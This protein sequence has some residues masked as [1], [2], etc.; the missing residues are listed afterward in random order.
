MGR[1]SRIAVVS[2]VVLVTLALLAMPGLASADSGLKIAG[3]ASVPGGTL[4][5]PL[6]KGDTPVTIEVELGVPAVSIPIL[7]TSSTKIESETGLPV[8]LTDDDRVK[9]DAFVAGGVITARKLELDEF[10]EIEVRGTVSGLPAAGLT[11]PLA[12]G[13]TA[14]LT[15]EVVPG[16]VV[17]VVLTDKTKVKHATQTLT[18]GDTVKVEAVLRN[19]QLVVTEL[20]VTK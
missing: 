18:N 13:T 5:L 7:I 9:V 11:L 17:T 8:T 10:P 12:Q 16:V 20:R 3:F 2:A 1:P 15:V 6:A 19:V 4:D 14:D